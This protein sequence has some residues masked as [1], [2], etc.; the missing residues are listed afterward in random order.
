VK[1]WKE[2]FG[3]SARKT[4]RQLAE[5]AWKRELGSHLAEL[6]KKFDEWRDGTINAF[7]LSDLIHEFHQKPSRRVWGIYTGLKPDELVA[8]AVAFGFLR[9]D[10]VPEEVLALLRPQIEFFRPDTDRREEQEGAAESDRG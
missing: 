9:E 3:K 10:E 1:G 8:R 6:G 5:T 7:E 4:L 2:G